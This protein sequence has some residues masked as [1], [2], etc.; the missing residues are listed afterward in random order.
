[1]EYVSSLTSK[2]QVTIP[3]SIRKALG[4]KPGEKVTFRLEHGAVRI[5]P[6]RASVIDSYA[7]VKLKG[8]KSLK[9]LRRETAERVAER[10][11]KRAGM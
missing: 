7:T 9:Q 1:M 10:A 2:G 6:A 5:Q 11:L 8:F 4:L 3:A